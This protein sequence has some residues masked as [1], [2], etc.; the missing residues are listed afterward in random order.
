MKKFKLNNYFWNEKASMVWFLMIWFEIKILTI[1]AASET[2][3]Y[4]LILLVHFSMKR[5]GSFAIY[6]VH[7][8]LCEE[9]KQIYSILL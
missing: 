6:F 1:A 2:W 5:I 8:L 4:D 9:W 7:L 3:N